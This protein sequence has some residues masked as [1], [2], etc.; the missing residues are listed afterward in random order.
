[1]PRDARAPDRNRRPPRPRGRTAGRARSRRSG[2]RRARSAPS[3]SRSRNAGSASVSSAG[4]SPPSA[5]ISNGF[6]VR[7]HM[8]CSMIARRMR[9]APVSA[10]PRADRQRHQPAS[11]LARPAPPDGFARSPEATNRSTRRQ[12]RSEPPPHPW[13]SPENSAAAASPRPPA[14]TDHP[15]ARNDRGRSRCSHARRKV[16][17]IACRCANRSTVFGRLASGISA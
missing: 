9:S 14:P 17:S 13:C 8:I 3:V 1:M 7:W 6:A 16:S 5:A 4:S 15:A 2:R 12:A 10:T 11:R